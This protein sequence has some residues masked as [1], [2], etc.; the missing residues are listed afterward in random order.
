MDSLSFSSPAEMIDAVIHV[1]R[2][3]NINADLLCSFVLNAAIVLDSLWFFRYKLVHGELGI[4][5]WT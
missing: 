1:D 2:A 5:C 4:R 3:F